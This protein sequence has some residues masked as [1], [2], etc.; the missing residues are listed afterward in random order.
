MNLYLEAPARVVVFDHVYRLAVEGLAL[1][2]EHRDR[3]FAPGQQLAADSRS[4]LQS[5]EEEGM[6]AAAVLLYAAIAQRGVI[7]NPMVDM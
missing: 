3:G 6:Q 5:R 7:R 2:H 1:A 4:Q